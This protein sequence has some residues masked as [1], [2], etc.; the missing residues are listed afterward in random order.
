MNKLIS[1]NGDLKVV[2]QKAQLEDK[3]DID[4]TA[5]KKKNPDVTAVALIT[6][7]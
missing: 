2:G 1:P 6:D 3:T 4:F 5:C 7:S